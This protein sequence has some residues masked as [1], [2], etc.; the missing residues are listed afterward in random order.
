MKIRKTENHHMLLLPVLLILAA[1]FLAT[2]LTGAFTSEV[3]LTGH[4]VNAA[5]SGRC[6]WNSAGGQIISEMGNNTLEMSRQCPAN[7]PSIISGGCNSDG[8]MAYLTENVPNF[9]GHWGN[10]TNRSEGWKC[11]QT[12]SDDGLSVDALCCNV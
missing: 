3:D 2:S 8:N 5:V 9:Y 1:A 11:S 10:S 4:A 6:A 12:G 7:K